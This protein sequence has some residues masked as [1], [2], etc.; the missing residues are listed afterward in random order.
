MIH[1]INQAIMFNV[2][3]QIDKGDVYSIKPPL[4]GGFVLYER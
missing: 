1:V 2:I 3:N 4:V